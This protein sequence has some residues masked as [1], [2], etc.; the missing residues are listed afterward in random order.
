CHDM[1]R[2][3]SQALDARLPWTTRFRMRI[4]YLIC[5]W[6]R[7]YRAQLALLRRAVSRLGN[8]A[9]EAGPSLPPDARER[10]KKHLCDHS[11]H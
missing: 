2:L 6:C 4:H 9:P 1:S 7:R 3:S 10:I 5:A 11:G 8:S